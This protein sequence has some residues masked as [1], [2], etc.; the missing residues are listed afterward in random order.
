MNQ[1]SQVIETGEP[2][3]ADAIG[4]DSLVWSELA[5]D[6]G[7]KG[8]AQE[9]AA[10]SVVDLYR[11]GR[12]KLRLLPEIHE[13]ANDVNTAEIRRALEQKL[14]VSLQLD[15][16]VAE[17]M[18]GQTPLQARIKRQQQERLVAIDAL[19]DEKLVKKLQHAFAAELD[20]ASVV[21]IDNN[22]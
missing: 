11:D 1:P 9:I 2:Q 4:E 10:N 21:K 7:L 13:L 17:A 5:Y 20:E 22:H 3:Q 6:L 14:G 12:L 15:L 16:A 8:L 18:G 19:K